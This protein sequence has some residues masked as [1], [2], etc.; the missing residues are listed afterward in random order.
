MNYTDEL[1]KIA[2][3]LSSLEIIKEDIK[4]AIQTAGGTP[5]ESFLGLANDIYNIGI[6]DAK[7][8]VT[9]NTTDIAE[10]KGYAGLMQRAEYLANCRMYIKNAIIARG[11]AVPGST[12]FSEYTDLIKSISGTSQ[13]PILSLNSAIGTVT[14]NTII[15]VNTG[16]LSNKNNYRYTVSDSLPVLNTNAS[17]WKY[18]NGKDEIT[19]NNGSSLCIVE[20]DAN[21]LIVQAGIVIAKSKIRELLSK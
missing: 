14:G 21:N 16:K 18:W 8:F 20:T 15:T 17:T 12:K 11:V 3:K 9:D 1:N 7:V 19:V 5:G 2:E 4:A 13:L 6:S 10:I